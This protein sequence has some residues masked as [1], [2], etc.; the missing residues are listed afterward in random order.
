MK[1]KPGFILR[2]MSGEYVVVAV[3]EAGRNF[4]GMVRLNETGA[5]LWRELANGAETD[6]LTR[7]ITERYE[8][9]TQE[10]ARTDVEEF[11]ENIRDMLE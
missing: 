3:G 7:K 8:G 5:Y 2:E 10:S 9:V 6:E 11:L 4:N 1:I